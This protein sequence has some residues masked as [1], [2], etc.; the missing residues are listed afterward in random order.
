MDNELNESYDTKYTTNIY[1]NNIQKNEDNFF[2]FDVDT[3]KR[4]EI[5]YKL[6][7]KTPDEILNNFFIQENSWNS[8]KIFNQLNYSF[9]T[10]DSRFSEAGDSPLIEGY[11]IAFLHH[12]PIVLNPNIFWLLILQG[13]SKHMEI[14]NNS[15]R[16]RY[17]FVNFKGKKN[18]TIETGIN[19]FRASDE[20]WCLIIDKLLDETS[21][22]L[23]KMDKNILDLFN[24]K[25]STSTKEAE[26]SN[27]IT[28]LSC[29]KKY[30]VFTM[31]GTCGIP[32]IKIEGTVEDWELLNKKIL[33][34]G[35]L[36]EEIVF[37]T[38]ELKEVIKKIIETL[39]TKN[40]DV[41]FYKNI[42]QNID[43]STKCK[44]DI[45]NG[46]IIKLIPYDKNGK[47]VDFN[48][49][50]FKGLNIDDIPSEIVS[51]PFKLNNINKKGQI[52]EYNAE[53]YTGIFGVKQDEETYEI[54]PIIGYA[55][56]EVKDKKEVER[57]KFN[58]DVKKM[59]AV[60]EIERD[61]QNNRRNYI[62][63]IHDKLSKLRSERETEYEN[64][65]EQ[66]IE[67]EREPNERE[68]FMDQ[69][70]KN[71][72]FINNE[73]KKNLETDN[74]NDDCKIF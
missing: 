16:N 51:L 43:Q 57:K 38:N 55:I 14:K 17:K 3:S 28:F 10:C 42:V 22:K 6:K 31:N 29:F 8:D 64:Q 26:I 71:K 48:S 69:G 40:P 68:N 49:P 18:I 37:W 5:N 13:F 2:I 62:P 15:E 45:I 73:E 36:D 52:K 20:Q 7:K 44:H 1:E 66:N 4:P 63:L 34:I 74:N 25:F 70:Y 47:K 35:N 61:M 30:F 50:D 60:R 12:F 59:L 41:N 19:L 67:I 65:S 53:I 46:W 54:K 39:Q 32:K 24:K 72:D 56:V 27:S 23:N 21:K 9:E 58:E 11:R 33:E